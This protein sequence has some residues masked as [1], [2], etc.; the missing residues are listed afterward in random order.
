M[1]RRL[2]GRA[3]LLHGGHEEG[4]RYGVRTIAQVRYGGQYMEKRLTCGIEKN[5][6]KNKNKRRKISNVFYKSRITTR[7]MAFVVLRK[8]DACI[9][10]AYTDIPK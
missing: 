1:P 10:E 2:I 6:N 7:S 5:K 9:Y 3:G 8:A 4:Y